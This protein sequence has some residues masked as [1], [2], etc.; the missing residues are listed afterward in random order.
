MNTFWGTELFD[1]RNVTVADCLFPNLGRWATDPVN[2]N[3]VVFACIPFSFREFR[4]DDF[5]I[6]L[7]HAIL[8]KTP[9]L[10]L[11]FELRFTMAIV[12]EENQDFRTSAEAQE[13]PCMEVVRRGQNANHFVERTVFPDEE[14][15]DLGLV[16]VPVVARHSSPTRSKRTDERVNVQNLRRKS[17]QRRGHGETTK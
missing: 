2:I 7:L 14:A 12:S 4:A 6:A 5:P 10:Q 3:L 11:P 15:L 8:S 9:F 13:I 16:I 1:G 17:Q